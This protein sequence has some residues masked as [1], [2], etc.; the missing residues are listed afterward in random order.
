M[1]LLGGLVVLAVMAWVGLTICAG[2][3]CADPAGQDAARPLPKE[4]ERMGFSCW[5]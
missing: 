2:G 1:E 3:L 5:D 4:V